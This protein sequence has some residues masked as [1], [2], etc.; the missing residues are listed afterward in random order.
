[1]QV[2][3]REKG[4]KKTRWSEKRKKKR[5]RVSKAERK[6]TKTNWT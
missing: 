2:G 3:E 5:W 4:R 6:E 1:V